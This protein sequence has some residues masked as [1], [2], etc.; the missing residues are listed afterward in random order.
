MCIF[1]HTSYCW[2]MTKSSETGAWNSLLKTYENVILCSFPKIRLLANRCRNNR[3]AIL[4]CN[5]QKKPKL[6]GEIDC[7]L[8]Q[9]KKL[10]SWNWE[11]WGTSND[12]QAVTWLKLQWTSLPIV[13]SWRKCP[14]H[15]AFFK[16][17][18]LKSK[19]VKERAW[20]GFFVLSWLSSS[21]VNGET[22]LG[23]WKLLVISN[24]DYIVRQV[25]L[26]H[27]GFTIA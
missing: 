8:E 2:W 6:G 17:M 9:P 23:G 3:C 15:L 5:Q 13:C 20:C 1:L 7:L 24:E 11:V 19:L 18:F 21:S 27:S 12:L 26:F 4:K 25:V 22:K 14:D 16:A 10:H